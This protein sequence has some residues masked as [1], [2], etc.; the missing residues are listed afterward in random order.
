MLSNRP[1]LQYAAGLIFSTYSPLRFCIHSNQFSK[2]FPTRRNIRNQS[3][4]CFQE[5]DVWEREVIRWGIRW[6]LTMSHQFSILLDIKSMVQRAECQLALPRWWTM[7]LIIS[8]S[9][10]AKLKCIAFIS[11]PKSIPLSSQLNCSS[12]TVNFTGLT[13]VGIW[14]H[15][16]YQIAET[17][18]SQPMKPEAKFWITHQYQF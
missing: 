18:S 11:M 10:T 6:I 16:K 3:S 7:Q 5:L 9:A 1:S 17:S 8:K 14:C 15:R 4:E 2:H 12:E 13:I